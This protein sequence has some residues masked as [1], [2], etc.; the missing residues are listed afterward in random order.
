MIRILHDTPEGYPF[1][2][3][4]LTLPCVKHFSPQFKQKYLTWIVGS[5]RI[6]RKSRKGDIILTVYDFQGVLCYWIGLL[7]FRR[8]KTLGI[9]ILLKQKK[10]IRNKIASFMYKRALKSEWF[11]TTAT[12][13]QY[14]KWIA[15]HLNISTA[16]PT[17]RDV[18]YDSYLADA[19]K[20]GSTDEEYIFSGGRNGRDWNFL[21]NLAKTLPNVL[22]KVS[23]PGKVKK[24]F[25][26]DRHLPKN[27]EWHCDISSDEF[28]KLLS[29]ASIV[30]LP[31]DTEAP[32]G[33]IVIF[34]SA[35]FNK[36]LI[37]S[38]TISTQDYIPAN[39]GFILNKDISMW[40]KA[41]TTLLQD[42]AMSNHMANNLHN[43]IVENCNEQKY[44]ATI[45]RLLCNIQKNGSI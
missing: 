12:T 9:N 44:V 28:N 17:L 32:A 16:I 30:A 27:I 5:W 31:L 14:G 20:I 3:E 38:K 29:G 41:I 45:E 6:M 21:I 19:K 1:I 13:D 15:K 2:A 36:P 11:F 8:R 24:I 18:M 43:H 33:L 26:S 10:S 7:T 4:R 40:E 25:D 23:A 22:F 35:A 34:Q 37:V 42:K 39:G